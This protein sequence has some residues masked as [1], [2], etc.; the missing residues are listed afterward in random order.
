MTS[1]LLFLH[2]LLLTN[3]VSPG[4]EHG[5]QPGLQAAPL[6]LAATAVIAAGR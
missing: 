1:L 2:L 5:P 3:G 4:A 6:C